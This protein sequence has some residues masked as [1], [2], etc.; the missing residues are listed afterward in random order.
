MLYANNR[1]SAYIGTFDLTDK[2]DLEIIKSIRQA[3]RLNNKFSDKKLYLKL[4]G[5]GSN[6]KAWAKEAGLSTYNV[7]QCLP[8]SISDKA[9]GYIYERY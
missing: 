8:L 7:N 5:R 6:R 2:N 3:I 1:T 9:D 4:Q